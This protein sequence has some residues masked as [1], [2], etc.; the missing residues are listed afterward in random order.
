MFS[1]PHL[2]CEYRVTL[3]CFFSAF[4]SAKK[5]FLLNF[6]YVHISRYI[7]N[8]PEASKSEESSKALF[9]LY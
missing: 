8:D 7:Q 3:L 4:A 1:L 9:D 2:P 6:L 5:T